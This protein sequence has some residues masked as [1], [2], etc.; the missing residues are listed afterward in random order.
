MNKKQILNHLQCPDTAELFVQADSVR[1][2]FC[3]DGVYLRGIIEFSNYC[4]RDCF[5]CGLRKSND[6]I[7]RYRLTVDEIVEAAKNADNLGYGTVVLQSGEDLDY[8]VDELC[9]IIERIKKEASCI[10]TMAVG[11]MPKE[12]YAA[13]KNAGADRYLLK[14]ETSCRALFKKLKPDSDFDIRLQCLRWLKD[15]DYEV[16][17]GVMVGLPGQTFDILADDILLFKKLDLDMIG[18]GPF[19]PHPNTPLRDTQ[20]GSLDLTLRMVAL[21]RIVT[22]NTNIPATTAVGTI[23]KEGRQKALAC[24]AN[25]LM[26]NVTPP[27]YRRYYEIY[28][29]KICI[30]ENPSDCKNCISAMLASIGRYVAQG[31][32]NRLRHK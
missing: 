31:Y 7:T 32:G 9:R 19:I 8:S 17:S 21:T 1:K 12:D 2:R 16:G 20:C 10:V 6:K 26:P 29:D 4:K 11:E 15:L 3:G 5:Y 18:I 30:D 22:E 24:G 23:N 28:P 13:M 25:I 14:I 27:Q